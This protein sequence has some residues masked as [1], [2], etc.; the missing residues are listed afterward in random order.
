MKIAARW[1]AAQRPA[2]RPIFLPGGEAQGKLEQFTGRRDG[3]RSR[4]NGA[5]RASLGEACGKPICAEFEF[6]PRAARE[7]PERIGLG[8]P[9]ER[10]G[11]SRVVLERMFCPRMIGE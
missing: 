7:F 4:A 5:G 10:F 3:E 6:S 11:A 2:V 8:V 1:I 9:I